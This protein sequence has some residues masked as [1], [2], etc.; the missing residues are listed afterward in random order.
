[1]S[2]NASIGDIATIFGFSRPFFRV[3]QSDA[4]RDEERAQA[5]ARERHDDPRRRPRPRRRA[6]Q[7]DRG[8]RVG[9]LSLQPP[10]RQRERPHE[11]AGRRDG[12][13]LGRLPGAPAHGPAGGRIAAGPAF[14]GTYTSGAYAI[15]NSVR[16]DNA[17]YFASGAIPTPR[18][19]RRIPDLPAHPGG[20]AD[21]AGP[22]IAGILV[23][24]GNSEVH[25]TGE[26]W[27][28]MLWECYAELLRATGG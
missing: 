26:V 28:A 23:R 18:T 21:P 5:R 6:R 20:S 1:M 25:G 16:P 13:R 2:P 17:Y 12:R 27:C 15:D 10:G 14:G 22:P 8:A 24:R 9:P 3:S 4:R 7:P 11:P 19:S